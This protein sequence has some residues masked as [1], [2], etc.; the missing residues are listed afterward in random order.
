MEVCYDIFIPEKGEKKDIVFGK[1]LHKWDC[2]IQTYP[3]PFDIQRI[4]M[5]VDES[6]CYH[7]EDFN[8]LAFDFICL[9]EE[10]L[11][12]TKDISALNQSIMGIL[13]FPP[14]GPV[15]MIIKDKKMYK[16]LLAYFTKPD[17]SE[18]VEEK[19]V[20]NVQKKKSTRS[21]SKKPIQPKKRKTD[22]EKP[23]K[24]LKK[25]TEK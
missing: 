7:Y 8:M 21:T 11:K 6:G 4:E 1:K 24:K 5:H 13:Q 15:G 25:E 18:S 19:S 17:S 9:M 12:D 16:E 23:Q 20:V 10:A 2:S 22:N 3:L 14:Y